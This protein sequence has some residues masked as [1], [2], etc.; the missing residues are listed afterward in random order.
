MKALAKLFFG[1]G[2]ERTPR[3]QGQFGSMAL[4]QLGWKHRWD[5]TAREWVAEYI[6][7]GDAF[8]LALLVKEAEQ[9][10]LHWESPD[11]VRSYSI[12]F[13][14][15]SVDELSAVIHLA[16]KFKGVLKQVEDDGPV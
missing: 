11:E 4:R 2:A 9:W 14:L 10:M 5:N 6:N 16:A 1:A 8:R 15:T 12:C 13:A 7:G 3:E